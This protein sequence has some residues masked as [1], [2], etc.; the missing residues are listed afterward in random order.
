MAGTAAVGAAVQV[1]ATG[2]E[3]GRDLSSMSGML[4]ESSCRLL[5]A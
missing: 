3:E 4:A 5:L 2:I 1:L